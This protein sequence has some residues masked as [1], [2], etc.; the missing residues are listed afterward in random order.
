MAWEVV[1]TYKAKENLE[2]LDRKIKERVLGKIIWLKNNFEDIT[3]LPLTNEWQGFFK[4]RVGDWRVIYDA[5]EIKA[6]ITI[7]KIDRRDRVYK[8]R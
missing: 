1:L 7:H 6:K 5:D 4:L 3:P 8:K 2:K